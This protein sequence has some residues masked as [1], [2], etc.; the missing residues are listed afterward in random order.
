MVGMETLITGS[1][2]VGSG[3]QGAHIRLHPIRSTKKKWD[4]D[5][6]GKC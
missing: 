1:K 3:I 4:N 6:K 2:K 5:A